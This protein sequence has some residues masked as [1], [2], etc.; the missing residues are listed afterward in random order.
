MKGAWIILDLQE[1]IFNAI[2]II[3]DEKLKQLNFNYCTEGVVSSDKQ[4]DDGSY[5]ITYQD[6][7]LTAFPLGNVQYNKGDSV[8]V[9]ALNGD[10][11]K[12]R[13]ILTAK[14]KTEAQYVDF[15]NELLKINKTGINYCISD[16]P[17]HTLYS[18]TNE[19]NLQIDSE[20]ITDYYRQAY[21][22]ISADVTSNLIATVGGDYGISIVVKYEDLTEKTYALTMNE[23]TGDVYNATGRK[24]VIEQLYTG[25]KPIEVVSAKS[26]IT[27]FPNGNSYEYVEF[28]DIRVEYITDN[29][30]FLSERMNYK[31]EIF[32]TNGLA[33]KNGVIS[34]NL[35]ARVYKGSEDVTDR[36][37]LSRFKW[38]MTTAD[39]TV[40]DDW[41][42]GVSSVEIDQSLVFNRT[43]FSCSI[44]D[45]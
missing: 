19:V 11:S 34:T 39:G 8:Y 40:V 5:N 13:I 42:S 10:V 32:S 25:S 37:P 36:I 17:S 29:E 6:I 45:E 2:D 38:T 26:Y 14:Q 4:N 27:N 7:V 41:K 24:Y 1:Q 9:V 43:T 33:F 18:G 3:T 20:F 23:V 35:V 12:K 15:S 31:L 21:I 28:A 30:V 22:K 44:S 16:T